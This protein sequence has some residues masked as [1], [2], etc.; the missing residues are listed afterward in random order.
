M[1]LLNSWSSANR[2]VANDKVVTYSRQRIY[3][4]WTYLQAINIEYTYHSV[5]EYHR[6]CSKSYMYVGM[7]INTANSCAAAMVTKYTRSFKISDWYYSGEHAGTFQDIDGGSMCMADISIQQREGHMYD[8]IV[9]VR[10]DDV[11]L[12][13]NITS[14][15]SLFTS[16]NNRDYDTN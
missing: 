4:S 13:T 10:E 8:V 5:W 3:G 12:R 11:R 2:V 1:A 16:E 6:Y 14:P 7:D 15:Q 9:N